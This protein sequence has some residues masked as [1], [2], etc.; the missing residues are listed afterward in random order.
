MLTRKKEVI[1][2]LA[3]V[4]HPVWH[5]QAIAVSAGNSRSGRSLFEPRVVIAP[6]W[7]A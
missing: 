4:V 2:C 7:T 5:G 3:P 6:G 1:P